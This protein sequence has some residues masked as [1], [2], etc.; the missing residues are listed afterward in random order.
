MG[1]PVTYTTA[2][3]PQTDK[4]TDIG[5]DTQYQ[6]QG[7]NY[8]LTLRGSYIH[9]NQVLDASFLNMI[10]ANPTDTLNEA[11]GYASLAYGND[12]RVVLT[13][14]YFS[15]WGSPDAGLYAEYV[16]TSVRTPR[17]GSPRSPT[18]RLSAAMRRDGRG[19]TPASGCNIPGTT[20]STGPT[21][22]LGQQYAVPLCVGGN[23][24]GG[25]LD[26][27]GVIDESN[28]ARRRCAFAVDGLGIWR[29]SRGASRRA[30]EHSPGRAATRA[31]RPAGAG[32]KRM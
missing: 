20:N 24:A 14:Q 10:S 11:R 29:R 31:G 3:F 17:V 18:F 26:I 25:C 4:Y 21:S 1:V 16:R 23:V 13:G 32:A 6:Y 28:T 12:N 8:W 27:L 15:T 22:A 19:S 2:T 9:E 30:C 7:D 5:F